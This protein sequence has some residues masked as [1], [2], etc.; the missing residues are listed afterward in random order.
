M[1]LQVLDGVQG[2]VD[3]G[4]GVGV[5]RAEEFGAVEA[6]GSQLDDVD[7]DDSAQ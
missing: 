4:H 2:L 5:D 3:A 1:W 6:A 7:G